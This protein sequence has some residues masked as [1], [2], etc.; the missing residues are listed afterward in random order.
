VIELQTVEGP[1]GHE[2][3]DAVLKWIL[4]DA[5]VFFDP[6]GDPRP[7]RCKREKAAEQLLNPLPARL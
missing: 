2:T 1:A 6:V 7:A 4:G 5:Q 3:E